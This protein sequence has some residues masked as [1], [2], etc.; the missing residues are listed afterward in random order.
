MKRKQ[1]RPK[2]KVK[3]NPAEVA[4]ARASAAPARHDAQRDHRAGG[5]AEGAEGRAQSNPRNG[6]YI[7]GFPSFANPIG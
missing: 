7:N 6:D 1:P 5:R 2:S 3:D 4:T